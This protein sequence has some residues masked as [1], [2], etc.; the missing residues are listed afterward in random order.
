MESISSELFT[1][2]LSYL[3]KESIAA[4]ITNKN[5][6]EVI[7]ESAKT[8]I[9]WKQRVETLIGKYLDNVFSNWKLIYDNLI[10]DFEGK[11]NLKEA[12]MGNT[13]LIHEQSSLFG[14][15][16][17]I[18]S[19]KKNHTEVVKILLADPRVNPSAEDNDAIKSASTNGHA[20]VV[21]LLLDDGR[22]NP[23]ANNNYAIIIASRYNHPEVV[24]LLL[25]DERGETKVRGV[26]CTP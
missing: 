1:S 20:E 7:K 17:L 19:S 6:D 4:L 3:P 9:F 21:K 23:S 12:Q 2:I 26:L 16:A 15:K 5:F 18:A 11:V 8:N 25:E 13:H 14:S 24:K 10:E 22:A